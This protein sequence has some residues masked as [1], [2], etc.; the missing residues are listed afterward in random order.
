V[1]SADQIV[2]LAA[3]QMKLDGIAKGIDESVDLCAQSAARTPDSLIVAN[4]F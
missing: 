4:F 1:I 2:R 3:S